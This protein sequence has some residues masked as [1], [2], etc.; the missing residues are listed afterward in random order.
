MSTIDGIRVATG[1]AAGKVRSTAWAP[2]CTVTRRSPGSDVGILPL[3]SRITGTVAGSR[4]PGIRLS[5]SDLRRILALHTVAQH[6]FRAGVR[7]CGH[8]G[9]PAA[10][11]AAVGTVQPA[12]SPAPGR[13]V[14]GDRGCH[15]DGVL[16]GLA[17]HA[18]PHVSGLP[19]DDAGLVG[20]DCG[21]RT[22]PAACLRYPQRPCR[23]P[24]V[25][26]CLAH[27]CHPNGCST[28]RITELD[29]SRSCHLV[30]IDRWS[31]NV[32]A[33]TGCCRLLSHPCRSW[34][35]TAGHPLGGRAASAGAACG[36][37]H[38]RRAALFPC[39]TRDHCGCA[40]RDPLA[41]R[42]SDRHRR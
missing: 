24:R 35:C 31:A 20:G 15:G 18:P 12:D 28:T 25:P 13:H 41:G 17:G 8:P 34:I 4:S 5:T 36:S 9:C 32:G 42:R 14:G 39:R 7:D 23:L 11:V 10:R 22:R 16:A 37:G 2:A 3:Y 6:E 21:N 26:E 1:T 29:A 19:N 38:P 33:S 30:D 40:H 27:I